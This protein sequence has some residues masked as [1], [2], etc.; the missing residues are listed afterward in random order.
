MFHLK[1]HPLGCVSA[2]EKENNRAPETLGRV[3]ATVLT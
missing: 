2:L 1:L 3:V